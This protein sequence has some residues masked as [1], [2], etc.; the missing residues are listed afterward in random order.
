MFSFATAAVLGAILLCRHRRTHFYLLCF[1]FALRLTFIYTGYIFRLLPGFCL[2][3][4]G[5][6]FCGV[7]GEFININEFSSMKV[8]LKY[9]SVSF[10]KSRQG[11]PNKLFSLIGVPCMMETW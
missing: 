1:S 5:F 8:K 6:I 11:A 10:Y 9:I 7:V 3:L 4:S 2:P